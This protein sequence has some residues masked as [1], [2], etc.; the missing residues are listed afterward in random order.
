MTKKFSLFVVAIF[1]AAGL[2]SAATITQTHPFSGIPN[3]SGFLTFNQFDSNGGAWILQSI[4]VSLFLQANG[5]QIAL[6]NDSS[7]PASGSFGFGVNGSLSSTDVTL[8]DSSPQA[9]PQQVIVDYNQVFGL[10][11]DNGDGTGNFDPTPPDGLFYI[12][13]TESDSSSGFVGNSFWNTGDVGF[14]GTGTYN[15]NYSIT[16]WSSYNGIGGIQYAVSPA[17][18]NGNITVVYTYTGTIP[19]PATITLLTVGAL[20]LFRRKNK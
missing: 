19:E 17:T 10:D 18:A 20:A 5:A 8:L 15:I 9:I 13:G 6:D 11:P 14:L 12:C 7:L 2:V 16:Q 4:Q 3:M 1:A